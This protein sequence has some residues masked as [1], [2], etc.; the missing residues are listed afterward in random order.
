MRNGLIATT[1]L[2]RIFEGT[3]G[4]VFILIALPFLPI[5]FALRVLLKF[6]VMSEV[7]L[8]LKADQAL[9][10]EYSMP[11]LIHHFLAIKLLAQ[12][13]GKSHEHWITESKLA[14][15]T[16]NMHGYEYFEDL[17][18]QN[19]LDDDHDRCDPNNEENYEFH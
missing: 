11:A 3:M 4:V 17:I 15:K 13:T 2:A 19:S 5:Y 10:K 9:M 7:F 1:K 6:M 12:F 16:R 18:S 14:H 8:T